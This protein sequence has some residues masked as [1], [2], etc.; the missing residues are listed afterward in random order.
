M[1]SS[2][3]AIFFGF[4]LKEERMCALWKFASENKAACKQSSKEVNS[5]LESLVTLDF[6]KVADS[7]VHRSLIFL[8][9]ANSFFEIA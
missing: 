3:L 8:G 1:R 4:L 7:H 2:T 5:S 6:A 9:L